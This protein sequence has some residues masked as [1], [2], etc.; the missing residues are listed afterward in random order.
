MPWEKGQS[1]NPGG[2]PKLI[3]K[4]RE[5]AQRHTD[6]A[7]ETLVKVMRDPISPPAAR[8]AAAG[9]LLDRGY[10][11]PAQAVTLQGDEEGG[12]IVTRVRLVGPDGTDA[13]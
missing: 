6:E 13:I 12:P 8:V 5:L 10:G 3:T 11:K 9:Q 4:V 7:V 1:G 2:R